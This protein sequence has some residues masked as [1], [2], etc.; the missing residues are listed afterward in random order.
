MFLAIHTIGQGPAHRPR[1]TPKRGRRQ[2]AGGTGKLSPN[3]AGIACTPATQRRSAEAARLQA[4]LDHVLKH[5]PGDDPD[6]FGETPEAEQRLA[7]QAV[8]RAMRLY[9]LERR[10]RSDNAMPTSPR[11]E[12]EHSRSTRRQGDGNKSVKF[13]LVDAVVPSQRS[14]TRRIVLSVTNMSSYPCKRRCAAGPA[15]ATTASLS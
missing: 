3:V 9:G 5:G 1:L 11:G 10:P 2:C 14:L 4:C 13:G 8:H 6:L 15:S 7:E 12:T